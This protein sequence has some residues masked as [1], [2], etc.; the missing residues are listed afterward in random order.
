MPFFPAETTV[1]PLEQSPTPVASWLTLVLPR[2]APP[3]GSMSN[4]LSFQCQA[5]AFCWK[6]SFSKTRILK[7]GPP[8]TTFTSSVLPAPPSSRVPLWH[9][10]LWEARHPQDLL[11]SAAAVPGR[12]APR[13]AYPPI[14]LVQRLSQ[15]AVPGGPWASTDLRVMG[16]NEHQG[17]SV[18][19]CILFCVF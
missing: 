5:S 12:P 18:F 9:S 15:C 3:I 13:Q 2:V 10:A 6:L 4:Q 8:A 16:S 11:V 17:T 19:F 1:K 7:H 14:P